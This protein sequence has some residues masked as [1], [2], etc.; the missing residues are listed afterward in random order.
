MPAS[1]SLYELNEYIRRVLALNFTEPIWVNCEIAQIKEVRGNVY[2]DLIHH[3]EKTNEITA[4]ISANIWYKSFLFLKNKLGDLLP[5][6]LKEGTHV[7]MKVQVEF[8]ERY[9]LKLIIEDI[10][11][12]FT[13]GQMEMNRQKILQKLSNEGLLEINKRRKLSTVISRVAV[14][15]SPGAAGYIDFESHIRTNSYGYVIDITM[16]QV[17]LQGQNTEREVCHA[18]DLID[19]QY[20]LYD[21]VIIIRGGGSKLDLSGFDSFNIGAKIS[22]CKLPVITGIG[23][24]VDSTVAD[25]V[26]F[27]SLKTP[28][29]V[30]DYVIEHNFNFESK[31]LEL[32]YWIGQMAKQLF[33]QKELGLNQVIQIL[34]LLPS[35]IIRK[36]KSDIA[37]VHLNISFAVTNLIQR[38]KEKLISIDHQL[39]L[40]DPKNI[41]KRGFSIVRQDGKIIKRR[42]ELA[43][44][45]EVEIEFYD[46]QIK[47]KQ[48]E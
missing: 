47:I 41:L 26:A 21:C 44:K 35:E 30:A 40:M 2:L 25:V 13:I 48:N 39:Q 7:M 8:N 18:F 3:D 1:Y 43:K 19:E 37:N 17:A 36:Q 45:H 38:H 22:K 10:D 27:Q 11:P 15:S 34:K 42:F 6:L 32:T 16:F 5:S 31:I 9:G 4:Q 23:H 33:R 29:A 14:I 28:T 46:G 24:D 20:E 12:S